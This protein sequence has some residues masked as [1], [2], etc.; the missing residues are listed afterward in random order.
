MQ[1]PPPLVDARLTEEPIPPSLPSPPPLNECGAVL[2]FRRVVRGTHEGKPISA[3]RYEV[4]E[5]MAL[6]KITEIAEALG[7]NHGALAV[8]V[9]HRHGVI[10]VGETVVYV[11]VRAPTRRAA[12]GCVDDIIDVM[13]RDAPIWRVEAMP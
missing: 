10:R 6:A 1:H 2:T 5:K 9:I 3:V 8:T 11:A 12:V 4:Y 7:R 13:K